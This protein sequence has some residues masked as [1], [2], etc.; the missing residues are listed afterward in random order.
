MNEKFAI[1]SVYPFSGKNKVANEAKIKDGQVPC[2]IC[3]KGVNEPW[4]H[5][6]V[7]VGGGDW[8]R[9]MDE[10]NDKVPEMSA[11]YMGAWPVGNECHR[12]HFAGYI[13]A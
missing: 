7:V 13:D 9:T 5:T 8:A 12:K 3:G 1:Y 6:A 2:A 11:G 10:A 4:P